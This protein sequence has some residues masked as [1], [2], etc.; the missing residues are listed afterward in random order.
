MK[1]YIKPEII[2]VKLD[3]EC[4]LAG[5]PQVN[6]SQGNGEHFAPILTLQYDEDE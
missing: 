4:I 6:N 5:S 1:K 2:E 3:S